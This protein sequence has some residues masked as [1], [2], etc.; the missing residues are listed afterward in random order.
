MSQDRAQHGEAF[1]T[2][3]AFRITRSQFVTRAGHAP[4]TPRSLSRGSFTSATNGFGA[5]YAIKNVQEKASPQIARQTA[6]SYPAIGRKAMN[7]IATQTCAG[8]PKAGGTGAV[9]AA[10]FPRPKYLGDPA[11]L[12]QNIQR[13]MALLSTSTAQHRNTVKV[14]FYGQSITE[15]S[16]WKEV[17]D[18]LRRRF[19]NANL[20]IENRALG[21]FSS[22][23]LVRAAESDLYSFYPDLLIFH[24]YGAH[25]DYE[26]IIRRAR[27]RTTSEVLI[28]TDH[29]NKDQN[30]NEETDPAKIRM[31]GA[32]WDS[33]MNYVHLPSVA[34]KYNT[35]LEDQRNAWK[36]YLRDN[37]LHAPQLLQD[38]V[39]P[40]A[41]GNFVMAEFAKAYLVRRPEEKLDPMNTDAVRTLVVGRD[42]RLNG[43]KLSLPFEGNRVDVIFK[44]GAR[45][46]GAP[47][48]VRVDGRK[49]SEIGELYSFTRALSTPGGKWPVILKMGWQKPLQ[50]EDWAMEVTRDPQNDKRFTFSLSGSKTGP[51]GSGASDA[52]FVSCSGRI[53]IDPKDW[54][55]EYSLSLPG[56]KPVPDH[57]T[58]RWRVV[59]HFMDEFTTPALVDKSIEAAVTLAQGLPNGHHTLEIS[60]PASTSIGAVRVYKPPFASTEAPN[61]QATPV[62]VAQAAPVANE[63][64]APIRILPLG[65]SITQGGRADRAEYTYRYPLFYRLKDAGYNVDF[66]G[67]M[68][69]GLSAE[70]KWPDINGVAFDLD[71]EGHYGWKTAA[72]R[73][74]LRDWM[75]TYPAPPDIVLIHLVGHLLCS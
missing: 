32:M 18:D 25:D 16:W 64:G 30:L 9:G 36:R 45:A 3:P 43:G 39:H 35:G 52:M 72:A 42:V 63:R 4:Q 38:G 20:Q 62:G 22:Q 24:V 69:Q 10:G 65:D 49:P 40:N 48:S 34:T 15:G 6:S 44:P 68:H 14:L 61:G 51:D 33:F 27:E 56:I 59:P 26:R 1:Q 7:Q 12:G 58:V 55:V 13:T 17:A 21:G 31:E 2:T 75:A 53:V 5:T 67:S 28:Q 60:G 70:A 19:P 71:H 66:I 50:V 8:E 54:N 41:R 74:K 23:L 47:A 73:D 46:G 37:N 11:K 29:A 57:L